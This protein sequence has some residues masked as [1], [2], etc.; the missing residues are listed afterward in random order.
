MQREQLITIDELRQRMPDLR[1]RETNLRNQISALDT[2]QADREHYLALATDVQAFLTTLHHRADIATTTDR[3]RVLRLV[4]KDV[5]IGPEN[6]TVRPPHPDPPP[7][8]PRARHRHG[9]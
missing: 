4:V 8:R 7:R 2:Q 6:I 3:Q 5:L 1:A 9:G